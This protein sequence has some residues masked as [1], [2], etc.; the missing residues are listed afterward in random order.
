ML[1]PN[2][3]YLI[4]PIFRSKALAT[5]LVTIVNYCTMFLV[6]KLFYGLEV[7]LTLPGIAILFG[8]IGVIGF[9]GMYLILPE[10]EGRSL[11]DIGNYFSNRKRKLTDIDI[12]YC[13]QHPTT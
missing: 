7:L 4:D 11:E 3:S 13:N 1:C 12:P 2:D 9:V 5:G 8:L 10:T 6:T